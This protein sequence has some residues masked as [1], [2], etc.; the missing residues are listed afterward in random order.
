M[1]ILFVSS[2]LRGAASRK[3]QKIVLLH[4]MFTI[5]SRCTGAAIAVRPR[6]IVARAPAEARCRAAYSK[7][8]ARAGLISGE[9]RLTLAR[10]RRAPIIWIT[11]ARVAIPSAA[12]VGAIATEAVDTTAAPEMGSTGRTP[13]IGATGAV[14]RLR[15]VFVDAVIR[16]AP[17]KAV[18]RA[19]I[20]KS[21]P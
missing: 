8:G 11:V 10:S 19:A 4:Q 17:A 21:A 16:A 20:A 5:A 13:I 2:S 6:T 1:I 18:G 7:L 9:I 3:T 15:A 12:V 14:L